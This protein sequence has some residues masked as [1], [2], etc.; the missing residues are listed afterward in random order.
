VDEILQMS[1]DKAPD[2]QIIKKIAESGTIYRLNASQAAD[3]RRDGVS[4][5]VVKYMQMTY[6]DAVRRKQSRED[7][8]DWNP[9]GSY[10][11]GGVPYGWW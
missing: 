1:K 8:R 7:L 5:P 10:W 6:Q 3:L 11:Y 2:E 4:D 9:S